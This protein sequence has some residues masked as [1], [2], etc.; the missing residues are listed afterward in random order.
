M[1]ER[2][3]YVTTPIYYPNDLPHIGHAYTTVLADV[4]ARWHRLNG[5]DVF[6]LTGTDE[7]GLKLQRA[8]EKAGLEPKEFVDKMAPIFKDYWARLDISYDRFIRTTDEDHEEVVKEALSK[9]YS[10]GLIYRGIY[11]GWYCA[12]CEKFY[13]EGEYEEQDGRKMCPTHKRELEW[14]EEETYFLKLSEYQDRVLELIR[15]GDVVRP[16][17]YAREVVS[18][19]EREGLRD[20]SIARPKT[21]VYWGIELPFDERFVVYVWVDALLNYVTGAGYGRESEKF[22]RYWPVVHH[23]IGKDILWF[24]TA[25]WFAVLLMLDLPPPRRVLVH[26]YIIN[27]GLKMG[28]SVGNVVMIDD[29]LE[30]YGSADAV[31]YLLMRLL[32]LEKDVEFSFELLDSMYNSELA[33]TYGNLVRRLGVLAK[34]KLGGVVRRRDL[35]EEFEDAAARTVS[36]V[37]RLMRE[38]EISEALVR[39]FDLLRMANAYLNRT[40]PWKADDP[41]PSLYNALEA[42]R[43]ATSLLHPVQPSVT[44]KVA[45]ALGFSIAGVEDLDYG[46]AEEFRVKE[47]P[48]LFKKVGSRGRAVAQAAS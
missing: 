4:L 45:D 20:L 3:F 32:N 34:R 26:A 47:A 27:R 40:A 14:V 24:H 38:Y 17:G 25:I 21:R 44:A 6:F 41:E 35:E 22:E 30:R 8:A 42:V 39:T 9:L 19:L 43:I 33:D 12:S 11:K 7:H 13:S 1:E 46:R 48:I 36:E 29:M 23:V 18:K 15:D 5:Y 31:R 10:K 2:A 28:K 16:R 37:S